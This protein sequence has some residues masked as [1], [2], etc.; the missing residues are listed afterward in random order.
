MISSAQALLFRGLLVLCAMLYAPELAAQRGWQTYVNPRFE[1]SI[2][3]PGEF[4]QVGQDPVN[5]DG[6]RYSNGAGTELIIW[7][8]YNALEDTIATAAERWRGYLR[9]EGVI[10]TYEAKGGDWFVLSG[11]RRTMIYYQRTRFSRGRFVTF[12]LVYPEAEK[13]RWNSLVAK[14][15]A[16]SHD[17]GQGSQ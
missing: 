15:A 5:G 11:T 17:T 4:R 3:F 8:E 1:Y 2:C 12:R 6:R 13:A 7:G 10:V 16:C 9:N 14:I